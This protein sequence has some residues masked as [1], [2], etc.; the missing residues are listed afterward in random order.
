MT[1]IDMDLIIQLWPIIPAMASIAAALYAVAR[2]SI[3]TDECVKELVNIVEGKG[4]QKGL[5]STVVDLGLRLT[6][7]ETRFDPFLKVV[8]DSL[9]RMVVGGNPLDAGL[10]RKITMGLAS[11]DEINK[12]DADIVKEI[13]EKGP[14]ALSL[15]VVRY[16]LALKRAETIERLKAQ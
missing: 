12:L 9:G 2:K 3:R 16:W 5:L 6:I 14:E 15:V 4:E 1:T 8:E 10:L 13:E 11:I 7:L